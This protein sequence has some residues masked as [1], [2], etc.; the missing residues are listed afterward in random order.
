MQ[1]RRLL[2]GLVPVLLAGTLTGCLP[3]NGTTVSRP[4]GGPFDP[5]QN[6]LPEQL[7]I[8]SICGGGIVS[9]LRNLTERYFDVAR[10]WERYQTYADGVA[11]DGV[12][13]EEYEGA[14]QRSAN[15]VTYLAAYRAAADELR[16]TGGSV[17]GDFVADCDRE[18]L[19]RFEAVYQEREAEITYV[20][21]ENERV[22]KRLRKTAGQ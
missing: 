6:G 20:E 9:G 8:E 7:R 3:S 2:A 13:V 16:A 21:T 14:E 22:T 1:R 19:V 18:V 17:T 15:V 5:G 10:E 4:E 12:T 11:T